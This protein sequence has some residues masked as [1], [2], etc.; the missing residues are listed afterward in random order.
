MSRVH[1][2]G[3]VRYPVLVLV[4]NRQQVSLLRG[5]VRDEIKRDEVKVLLDDQAEGPA[6]LAQRSPS[7]RGDSQLDAL[8]VELPQHEARGRRQDLNGAKQLV[9]APVDVKHLM[10]YFK[11]KG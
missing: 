11:R 8:A 1:R 5:G 7:P 2:L 4:L 3:L 9:T 10:Q 6:V